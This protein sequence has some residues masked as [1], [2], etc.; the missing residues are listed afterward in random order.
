MENDDHDEEDRNEDNNEENTNERN[1]CCNRWM[2][3]SQSNLWT[4]PNFLLQNKDLVLLCYAFWE[5]GNQTTSINCPCNEKLM[6]QLREGYKD[7]SFECFERV[8]VDYGKSHL[9]SRNGTL[10]TLFMFLW[11]VLIVNIIFVNGLIRAKPWMYNF[12]SIGYVFA[13]AHCR[14]NKLHQVAT[15][16]MFLYSLV[17]FEYCLG[18]I[19]TEGHLQAAPLILYAVL[20]S[21]LAV[22]SMYSPLPPILNAVTSDE[23]D[24]EI[25]QIRIRSMKFWT[26]VAQ[27]VEEIEDALLCNELFDEE[28]KKRKKL[29]ELFNNDDHDKIIAFF[30]ENK[31]IESGNSIN[32]MSKAA[33]ATIKS[34]FSRVRNI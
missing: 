34:S 2:K 14:R 17:A 32:S 18:L 15:G 1:K 10:S 23:S 7:Y 29:L 8:K 28:E 27:V 9:I 3:L 33:L 26:S 13:V 6:K 25:L 11:T 21:L 24:K 30:K 12:A 19:Y 31:N 22:L 5:I 20:Q 16:V 4:A